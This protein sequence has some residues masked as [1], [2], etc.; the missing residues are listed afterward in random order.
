[1]IDW[2]CFYYFVRNSIGFR[3]S[4]ISSRTPFYELETRERDHQ[5]RDWNRLESNTVRHDQDS[6]NK[7]LNDTMMMIAFITFKSSLVPLFEGLWTSNSWEFE[8]S[9]FRRN[10]TDDLGIDSPSLWPTEPR[11]HV[12]KKLSSYRNLWS[13]T[14]VG[15]IIIGDWKCGGARTIYFQSL[16]VCVALFY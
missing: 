8:L 12:S 11:L 1:M 15:A 14:T 6:P 13:M 2:C 16:S 7:P 3:V 9:G 10:R 5:I 4:R